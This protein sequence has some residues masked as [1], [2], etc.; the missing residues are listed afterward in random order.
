M[1][2]SHPF[3]AQ[4]LLV[5]YLVVP[6]VTTTVFRTFVCAPF[7]AEVGGE[8]RTDRLLVAD[9]T[10]DCGSA[11][12]AAHR[13]FALLMVAVWP[14]GVPLWYFVL[15]RDARARIDQRPVAVTIFESF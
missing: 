3:P 8:L 6:T 13:I 15:L 9:V 1:G 14:V 12:Y 5:T 2:I 10:V 7:D 11:S 4:A